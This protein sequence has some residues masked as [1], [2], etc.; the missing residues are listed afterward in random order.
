M[1]SL[2]S[3]LR[4]VHAALPDNFRRQIDIGSVSLQDTLRNWRMPAYR[5]RASL[6]DGKG[7]GTILYLGDR[8]QYA[9]WT[10][11][12]FGHAI[13]PAFLGN[14]SLSQIL[15]EY[16]LALAADIT[17]C[18]LNPWT[19]PLFARR[20]W[21]VMPLFVNCLI[22][23]RKPV[24][25]LITSKGANHPMRVARRLDYR[26]EHKESDQALQEFFQQML[27]PTV[28]NRHEERGFFSKWEDI[29]HVHQ[30]GVLI[31]AYLDDEWIG[32]ILLAIEGA[33]SIRI[34]NLGWRNGDDAWLKKGIVAALYYQSL[35]WA[36]EHGYT[37]FNMGSS[38]AFVKDG[39]LNFKLKWGATMVPPEV[40]FVNGQIEGSRSFVGAKLNLGS[41]AA[42]SF[43]AS[44]PLLE[45]SE[46][47]LRAISWN[48]E[49]P[50]QFHRQVDLGCAWVNLAEPDGTK[51]LV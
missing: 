10:H 25:E 42:Q 16:T 51:S 46:G 50:P 43:L 32:G 49:I 41:P 2:K 27:I 36:Q 38:S 22:D 35:T 11:K 23:L 28:Q 24:D 3:L 13:E 33:D 18:P 34:A 17:L 19:M 12:L 1:P 6:P 4:P 15:R 21:H 9:S 8:P 30:N 45:C 26:F 48:A 29:Q 5:V 40:R 20:G 37:E 7:E 47:R 44:T 39:P 31:A 14:F